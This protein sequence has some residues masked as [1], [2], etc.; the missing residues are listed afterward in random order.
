[1]ECDR[2]LWVLVEFS[3]IDS[4]DDLGFGDFV[5]DDSDRA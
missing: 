2:G 4:P 1:M 3:S 5:F